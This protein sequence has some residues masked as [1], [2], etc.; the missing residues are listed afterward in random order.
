MGQV[1]H[2]LPGLLAVRQFRALRQDPANTVRFGGCLGRQKWFPYA[3][4]RSLVGQKH[5][6]LIILAFNIRASSATFSAWR[7]LGCVRSHGWLFLPRLKLSNTNE[8]LSLA[9]EAISYCPHGWYDPMRGTILKKCTNLRP[10]PRAGKFIFASGRSYRDYETL[11]RAVEGTEVNVKVSGR[12]F[13]LAGIRL[14][15]EYGNHGLADLS[16]VAGLLV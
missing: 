1:V 4:L 6:P 14:A 3:V 16:R 11:A 9:P 2:L 15:Q 10:W 5:P 13:N 8:L 7:G 12:P